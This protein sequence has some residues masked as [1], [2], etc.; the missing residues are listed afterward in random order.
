M[1]EIDAL[2]TKERKW[3]KIWTIFV[4][5]SKLGC[6]TFG[7]GWSIVAQM[8]VEFIEKRKWITEEQLLD[9][10]S[11]SRSF[12]GIMVI[13]ISVMFGYTV[14]GFFGALAAAFGL[15]LPALVAIGI[16]TYFYTSLRDNIYVAKILNGVRSAVIPIIIS[17]AMKLRAKSLVSRLSYLLMIIS[18]LLCTFTKINKVLVVLFGVIVGL[19]Y[20]KVNKKDVVS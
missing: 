20:W 11:L 1:E 19:I 17:A 3:Q 15:A 8:Q 14:A 4:I 9:F 12:P 2:E 6:F 7:G 10:T 16:V 5:M 13:N 18:F